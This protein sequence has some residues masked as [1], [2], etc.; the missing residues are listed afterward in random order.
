M[1]TLA[2]GVRRY[3]TLRSTIA[4]SDM[5]YGPISKRVSKQRATLP[6]KT[7]LEVA[8]AAQQEYG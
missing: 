4:V 2:L 8:F 3:L 6:R 7:D 1:A 5:G